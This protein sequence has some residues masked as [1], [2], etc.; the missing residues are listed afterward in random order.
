MTIHSLVMS[1]ERK[2]QERERSRGVLMGFLWVGFFWGEGLFFLGC[3]FVLFGG[4]LRFFCAL[5]NQ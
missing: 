4:F 5:E 2:E 3:L 1:V